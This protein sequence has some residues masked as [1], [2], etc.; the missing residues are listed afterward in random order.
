M[1]GR[2][3]KRT[4]ERVDAVL[5]SLR[6]GNTRRAAAAVAEV[7]ASTFY[8]WMEADATF[9]TAVEKAEAEAEA[10]FAARVTS[11]ADEGTWQAAAW[12][13]ERRRPQDYA[14]RAQMDVTV[15]VRRLV[16]KAARDAGLDPKDVFAEVDAILLAGGGS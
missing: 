16:D 1:S 5:R 14:R 13:L 12:W 8:R 3:T 15:D 11:A 7:D 6:S 2:R 10:R 9:R 4:D